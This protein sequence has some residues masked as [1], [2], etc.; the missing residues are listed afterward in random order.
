MTTIRSSSTNTIKFGCIVSLGSGPSWPSGPVNVC[1][2][3]NS[4]HFV[5]HEC[6]PLLI[7]KIIIIN[8]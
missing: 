7:I 5:L 1:G 8:T 6:L 3:I 4:F 2:K